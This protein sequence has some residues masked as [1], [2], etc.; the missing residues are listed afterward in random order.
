MCCDQLFNDILFCK[1][2]YLS[3]NKLL[4]KYYFLSLDVNPFLKNIC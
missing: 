1:S 2:N 4:K 3:I